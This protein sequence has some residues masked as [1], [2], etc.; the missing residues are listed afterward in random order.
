MFDHIIG[1]KWDEVEES[2]TGFYGQYQT[3]LDGKG[4]FALPAKLRSVR[5]ASKKPLL[6]GDLILTKGLEGCL[7]LYPA[8]EWEAIQARLSSL[9]FTKKD[10][11]FFSRRFYSAAAVVTPDRTGRILV[12][13]HLIGEAGLK[14]ELAVIGVNRWIEIWNPEHYR[15]YLDQFAGSYEEV[16]ERMF[17][18]DGSESE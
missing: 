4:R 3:T 11:R 6:E 16:A 8:V 1:V 14:K 18:G 5:G 2:L 7:S 17:S 9:N 15:Y 10:F 13:A 12:P